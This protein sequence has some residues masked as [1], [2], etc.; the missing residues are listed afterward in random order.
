MPRSL[1]IIA[2]S[3]VSAGDVFHYSLEPGG[4]VTIGR[5]ENSALALHDPTVSRRHAKIQ[6]RRDGFYMMDV[7]SSLGTV[8]MG[9]R[10]AAGEENAR[11][12]DPDDEF[13]I[14]SAIFRVSFTPL[15][16]EADSE[17][18]AQGTGKESAALPLEQLQRRRRMKRLGA[19]VG[20]ALLA[21]GGLA[22]MPKKQG[23][24]KQLSDKPLSMPQE[25]VLGYWPAG[26]KP[27]QHDKTHAD[28]VQFVLPASDIVVEFEF[29]VAGVR[30]GEKAPVS[31]FLDQT[32]LGSLR[33]TENGWQHYEIV[34]PDT[35]QG[36]ERLLIFDNL[37]NAPK[38]P[39]KFSAWAVRNVRMSPVASAGEVT[40]DQA[41]NGVISGFD[42]IAKSGDS[43][44]RVVRLAQQAAASLVRE[45]SVGAIIIPI[46]IETPLPSV[47]TMR[48]KIRAILDDRQQPPTPDAASRH[49]QA[50]STVAGQLDAELW[51][52]FN[53][54]ILQAQY[55]AK[56]AN[57]IEAHDQLVAVKNMFPDET[58]FRWTIANRMY[59]DNKIVPKKVRENPSK[60][61]K[62]KE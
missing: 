38:Q 56:A 32:D 48:E 5:D 13:K 43:L 10:L 15:P 37:Q 36:R 59:S 3:G 17:P 4:E 35:L 55:A 29:R 47:E 23:V 40:V 14:G 51:R 31:V 9:A 26:G 6:C 41:L 46:D 57:S 20:V 53:N 44:F 24:P 21:V 25:R 60:Y 2:L 30:L 50:L 52:R 54:R 12:L 39:G 27:T 62:T 1:E 11:R 28:K 49:L 16:Q 34:V 61:R 8:L 18:V 33:G 22:L 45:M 58:D 19:L 42:A 7:G